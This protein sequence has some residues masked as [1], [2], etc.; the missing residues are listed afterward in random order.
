MEWEVIDTPIQL[1][2][3]SSIATPYPDK[4]KLYA[5]DKS[6]TSA[7]YYK[8]DAGTEIDLSGGFT[9]SGTANRLAYW[10]SSTVLAANA[11]LTQNRLL[12]ADSNGLPSSVGALTQGRVLFPDS[13]GLPTGDGSLFWDNT[14][15]ML[16][17]GNATPLRGIDVQGSTSALAQVSVTRTSSGAAAFVGFNADGAATGSGELVAFFGGGGSH[18]GTMANRAVTSL[19]GVYTA[20]IWGASA[21]GSYLTLETTPTGSTSRSERFRVGPSGQWGIGGATYG[22]SGQAFVSGGASAAPAW[23]SLDHGT[24]LAGLTDDDHTQYALLAGRASGQT[25]KGG[26]AAS[27]HLELH[28]TNHATK[29]LIKFGAN[30]AYDE[31]NDALAVGHQAPTA[32]FVDIRST[33]GEGGFKGIF[34]ASALMQFFS[35]GTGVNPAVQIV[36]GRGTQASPS[37]VVADDILGDLPSVFAQYDA[38]N[39]QQ[40]ALIRIVATENH[41]ASNHGTRMQ[42]WVTPN[43]GS[44][45]EVLTLKDDGAINATTNAYHK[46]VER[47]STPPAPSDGAEAN[48]YMKAD[49][50]IIQYNEG[51]TIRYKYLLLTGT[52]TT[53]AHTTSAP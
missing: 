45:T 36:R 25:L 9:G 13:N 43:A 12:T 6:G 50:F 51:G 47:S 34:D 33:A 21:K 41:G 17:V 40:C 18:D 48:V 30:G 5:K 26:T 20:E 39:L 35:Y 23:T 52:G 37:A 14:A 42:F 49:K 7:L 3:V 46:L 44:I 53:W 24:H 32:R 29:G 2:E 16:G 28:S 22:T 15:K 31:T 19:L 38:S 11:A 8:N 4:L 1:K 27:E 10:T